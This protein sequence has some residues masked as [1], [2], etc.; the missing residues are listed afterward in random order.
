MTSSMT[1]G[2]T[3]HAAAQP[4]VVVS[5]ALDAEERAALTA[6]LA[7]VAQLIFLSDL[8]AAERGTALAAANAL[9]TLSFPREV[10]AELRAHLGHVRLIQTLS[11]GVNQLPFAELPPGASIA[12]NAGAFAEPM[13]EHVL[14]MILALAKHLRVRHDELANGVFDHA[15][16]NR[17]LRGATVAILGFGGIGQ[18]TARL[19]RAFGARIIALNSSG[20]TT[21]PV[22]WVGTLADLERALRAAD[23]AVLSL[24]LTQRTRGLLGARELGWMKPDVIL[25]NVGRGGLID[26]GALYAHLR[27]HPDFQAGIDTWWREP[28]DGGPFQ[29][30]YPFCALPN[31][32]GSPHNS[33]NVPGALAEAAGHAADNIARFLRG[34]PIRGVVAREDYLPT[35]RAQ[36]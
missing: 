25:I 15:A 28:F 23:I 5:V 26:E 17:R 22:E 20:H 3:T 14:A 32:L 12:G 2:A 7:P 27:A 18:A 31:V 6:R 33:S 8:P 35:A 21:E 34:E 10:P 13:A 24:P 19:L 9:L 1:S 36:R 11:A 4:R 30:N 29:V 16:L